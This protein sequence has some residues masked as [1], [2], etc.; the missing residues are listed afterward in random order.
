L[1]RGGPHFAEEYPVFA[2]TLF[3][4]DRIGGVALGVVERPPPIVDDLAEGPRRLLRRRGAVGTQQQDG[5]EDRKERAEAHGKSL[6]D[7]DAASLAQR[8]WLN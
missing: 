2:V 8:A 4:V 1:L 6:H 5:D 3:E 7:K